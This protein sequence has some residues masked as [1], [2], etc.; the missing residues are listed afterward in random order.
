MIAPTMELFGQD[1]PSDESLMEAVRQRKQPALNA[2]YARHAA[3][4]RGII[5]RVLQDYT[6]ADDVLQESLL[7]IWREA[8]QYSPRL[9]KPLGWIV[10]IARRRAIDRSRRR[11]AYSRA[12]ERFE[13][14]VA[15]EP[16]SWL[17][18]HAEDDTTSNDLRKY[19]ARE[20][21][22]LPLSQREAIELSF[23]GGLSHREIA[24]RTQ[25]PLGTIK[26]RL[27]LGLRKLTSCVKPQLRKI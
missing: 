11:Q 13:A 6:E 27:E 17:R 14:Y 4:L 18:D 5:F 1:E 21:Q 23:F 16:R 12:R 3:K 26:T 8:E 20:I 10:T 7:Q 24:A 22:R 9:G 19:F 2:L 15:H 25:T